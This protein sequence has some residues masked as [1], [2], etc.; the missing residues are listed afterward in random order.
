FSALTAVVFCMGMGANASEAEIRAIKLWMAGFALLAVAGIV[1]SILLL[2]AGQ[3]GWGATA[4]FMP[5]IITFI[6]FVI[7]VSR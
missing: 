1:V 3:G 2:R 6:I 5:T 7:A 4:A